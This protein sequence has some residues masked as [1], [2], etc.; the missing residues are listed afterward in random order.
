[1]STIYSDFYFQVFYD[2]AKQTGDSHPE[3][4]FNGIVG[5]PVPASFL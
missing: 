4:S 2:L 5:V 3:M 1:M